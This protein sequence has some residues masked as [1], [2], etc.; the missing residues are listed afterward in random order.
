MI[1]L[2]SCKAYFSLEL[3]TWLLLDKNSDIFQNQHEKGDKMRGHM[4]F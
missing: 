4:M 1:I 2:G 3:I